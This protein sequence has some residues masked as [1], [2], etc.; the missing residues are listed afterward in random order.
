MRQGQVSLGLVGMTWSATLPDSL[1][2]ESEWVKDDHL[3]VIRSA[4]DG[5]PL[6]VLSKREDCLVLIFMNGAEFIIPNSDEDQILLTVRG[7]GSFG[8]L[9]GELA[10]DKRDL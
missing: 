4:L 6:P 7:L 5:Q 3:T 1:A 2:F 10:R 9:N 8:V